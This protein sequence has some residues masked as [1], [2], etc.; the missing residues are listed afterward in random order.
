M[1]IGGLGGKISQ[2][3]EQMKKIKCSRCGLYYDKSK[4]DCNHCGHIVTERELSKLKEK[5][6]FEQQGGVHLGVYMILMAVI[7][8]IMMLIF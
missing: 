1:S 2:L 7:L 3:K 6:E 8:F 5:I 4:G